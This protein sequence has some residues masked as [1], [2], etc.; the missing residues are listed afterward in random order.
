MRV[1]VRRLLAKRSD[2][3]KGKSAIL[4][5]RTLSVVV[6]RGVEKVCWIETGKRF[7]HLVFLCCG[8]GRLFEVP[9][10]GHFSGIFCFH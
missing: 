2:R 8:G 4:D 10:W 1:P 6:R 7:G 9:R 3:E 5:D